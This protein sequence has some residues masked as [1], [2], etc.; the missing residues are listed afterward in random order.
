MFTY[1]HANTPLGQSERAYYLSYFVV[2]NA[3]DIELFRNKSVYKFY[4]L[5]ALIILEQVSTSVV[6]KKKEK[7]FDGQAM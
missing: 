2:I 7:N 1:S 3:K 4:P 6:E 5:K